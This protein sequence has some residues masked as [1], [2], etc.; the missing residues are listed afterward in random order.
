MER[1]LLTMYGDPA[2]DEK[3]ELLGRRGGA[4]Y[5]EAAVD[6]AASLLGGGGSPHQVVNTYNRGTLPFLPDDAVIEVQ[7]AVGPK[8]P[9]PLP[10][11][12]VDP[13]YAGLMA[14]VTAYED[15]ALE[16]ALRGGRDRVFRALLA[17]PLVGQYAYADTLTDQLIAHNREH[18][19]WA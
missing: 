14:N 18:L 19:A 3:P 12:S 16:A 8:G 17:H 11:P 7:A 6:L 13:L 9:V 4:Y 15:L 10:V 5:S 1:Q 2:L